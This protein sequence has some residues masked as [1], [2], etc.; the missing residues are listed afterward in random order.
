MAF[1]AWIAS[2]SRVSEA[3]ALGPLPL[4]KEAIQGKFKAQGE[5]INKYQCDKI[6]DAL[7]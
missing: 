5:R 3:K 1:H 4:M 7:L 6:T 2:E